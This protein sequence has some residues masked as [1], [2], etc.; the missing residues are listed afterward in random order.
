VL[1]TPP[2]PPLP[3]LDGLDGGGPSCRLL[4]S[5]DT[6]VVHESRRC[7]APPYSMSPQTYPHKPTRAWKALERAQNPICSCRRTM[8]DQRLLPRQ[9]RPRST[10]P[11]DPVGTT[12]RRHKQGKCHPRGKTLP[13]HFVSRCLPLAARRGPYKW[14][15]NISVTGMFWAR[16]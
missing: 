16:H 11:P 5:T 14:H 2:P 4:A 1:A 10:A 15:D 9:P 12:H 3:P 7:Q 6:T 13:P 8:T